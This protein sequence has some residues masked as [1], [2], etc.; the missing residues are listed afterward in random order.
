MNISKQ[1]ENFNYKYI[2]TFDVSSIYDILNNFNLEWKINTYRQNQIDTTHKY[3]ESYY[4]NIPVIGWKS[5][6]SFLTQN[7][8][9][10]K[11][12]DILTKPIVQYLEQLHNGKAGIVMYIKLLPNS[13]VKEHIDNGEYLNSVRRH[14]I[15]IKTNNKVLFVVNEE[16]KNMNIGECWEIN[17]NKPHM[18]LNDGDERI[19]LLIDIMPNKFIKTTKEK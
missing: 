6:N 15:P 16:K 12:L 4:I 7:V 17:N 5:N 18:V 8:C 2:N 10:N 9:E 1:N 3:T 11:K 13:N 19:H 14:H